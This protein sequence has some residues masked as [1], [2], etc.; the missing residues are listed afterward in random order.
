V[1]RTRWG[2]LLLALVVG[3]A[4]VGCASG[5]KTATPATTTAT[6]TADPSRGGWGEDAGFPDEGI[7]D[8]TPP[9]S[10]KLKVGDT[11]ELS[12]VDTNEAVARVLVSKVEA[13]R[14]ESYNK[15]ER[16]WF[17]GVHVKVKAL[18]DEQS[19]LWGDFYVLM[20]GHHYD[21]DAYAERWKPSLDYVDLNA[22]ETAEGWL[23]F[24][25]PARHGEVVLGQ[26]DGDGKIATWSF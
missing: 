11:A 14:G 6:T 20:R 26:R 17:L 10:T 24:D 9:E 18:A 16:G 5:R 23:V 22:G 7:T 8:P 2:R 1:T 21:G 19:S 13:I 15:P 4:L 12:S 3:L 25:T